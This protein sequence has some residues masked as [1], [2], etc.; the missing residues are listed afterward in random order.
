MTAVP[1]DVIRLAFEFLVDNQDQQVNVW[2]VVLDT[3]TG[4]FDDGDIMDMLLT[5]ISTFFYDEMVAYMSDRV[6]GN[7]VRGYNRTQNAL[8][9]VIANTIDGA[10]GGEVHP[11]Q[12]TPLIYFLS[13]VPR[14]QGRKYYPVVTEDAATDS[15]EWLGAFQTAMA[16]QASQVLGNVTVGI[17]SSFHYVIVMGENPATVVRPTAAGVPSA[18]RTQRRRTLGRGS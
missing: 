4:G 18:P 12:V 13:S 15:A 17:T 2:D 7:F 8:M 6:T 9:P 14:V 10:N 3:V 11:L 1:G 5:G 16:T